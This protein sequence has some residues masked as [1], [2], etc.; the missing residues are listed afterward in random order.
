[1]ASTR[2]SFPEKKGSPAGCV[3]ADQPDRSSRPREPRRLK[4]S[5]VWNC[6]KGNPKGDFTPRE[7]GG[8]RRFS[9]RDRTLSDLH[10]EKLTQVAKWFEGEDCC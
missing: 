9:S 5:R 4:E 7:M 1:M 3:G 2:E 10:S 8:L 6:G